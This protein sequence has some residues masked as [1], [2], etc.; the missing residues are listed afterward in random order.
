MQP[1]RHSEKTQGAN[2]ESSQVAS[3]SLG[4]L[5]NGKG[6]RGDAQTRNGTAFSADAGA[7]SARSGCSSA[8]G[9]TVLQPKESI[10][11]AFTVD[12]E[13]YFQVAAL[14]HK[15]PRAAWAGVECRV[16]TNTARCLE[17]LDAASVHGTFFTLGWV[18]E[19]YPE[20]IRSIA[21]AGHEVASHGYDHTL[22]TAMNAQEIREDLAK[23]KAILE[24]VT[25]VP[26][27][28]YR[29]PTFS[30]NQHN[31]WVYDLVAEAGYRY[32]SSIYPIHHDLYGIPDAPRWRHSVREG[33]DEIPVTTLRFAGKN[34]PCAGGGYFRL[35][36]YAVYR[37]LLRHFVVS[38]QQ[39]AMFY[40][41]PWEL[42]PAQ[43]RVDGLHFKSR[44]R[45]YLNLERTAPRMQKLL[46]DFRWG[47]MDEAFFPAVL[48]NDPT[49]G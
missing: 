21:E 3:T 49:Q 27:A 46:R 12:V 37:R 22:L 10:V 38:E 48:T 35:L 5:Q 23:S 6:R 29:A 9:G 15:F 24:D 8:A 40:T 32:S 33:L 31:Q 7:L 20:L 43:P 17:L 36:P 4:A 44:F 34:F 45:H 18:A 39:P 13:D 41:H 25:G 47:R 30:I 11:N 26:V 14:A 1:A 28:G 16:E 19:R 42:D 2:A